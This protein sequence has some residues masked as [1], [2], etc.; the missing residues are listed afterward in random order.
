MVDSV[1]ECMY[2]KLLDLIIVCIYSMKNWP[3]LQLILMPT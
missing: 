1:C 3:V 2:V